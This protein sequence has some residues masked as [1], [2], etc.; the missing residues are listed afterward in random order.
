[1]L[2]NGDGA[3]VTEVASAVDISKSS[4]H[5]Q[6]ATLH[7]AGYLKKEDHKYY[8]SYQFLLLGQLVRDRSPLFQFGR[9][10]AD[11]L[12]SD[13]GHYAYL[14]VEENG[15][16][17]CIYESRGE[18]AGN[19]EY[20]SL[21]MQKRGPMH[22]TA[23]GKAILAHLPESRVEEIVAEHG[24]K[25]YT[26]NTITDKSELFEEL[27]K[28]RSQGYAVNDE[29]EII[30]FRAVGAPVFTNDETILGSVSVSGP[31]TF[32]CDGNFEARIPKKVT[33]AAN[34]ICIEINMSTQSI[35]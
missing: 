32:L 35:A 11:G 4:A 33:N 29:E 8:L 13:T 3:G 21:K 20:Q 16:G 26:K 24:L 1:M 14:S 10:K 34:A 2:A 12:A 18:F 30:G 15:L 22:V 27:E 6:L 7:N 31:T 23:S 19:Y 25:Q 28:I 17:T 5:S 9:K